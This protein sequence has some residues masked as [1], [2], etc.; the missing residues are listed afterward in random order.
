MPDLDE[1]I[2][3]LVTGVE[4]VTAAEVIAAHQS[5]PGTAGVRY[6]RAR[7]MRSYAMGAVAMAAAICILVVVLVYGVSSPRS[8]VTTP[9]RP[10]GVPASWQKVTFGG[11]S[12]Y[13]PGIG[14]PSES[15]SGETVES[16]TNPLNV[17]QWCSTRAFKA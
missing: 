10:A 7:R 17:P 14:P 9:T 11:L 13:A 6:R 4:P 3:E 15:E 1:Q 2:R 16:R 5:T 12:M 8:T